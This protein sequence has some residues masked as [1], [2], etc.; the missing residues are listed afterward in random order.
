MRCAAI[1]SV[2]VMG[3]L[4]SGCKEPNTTDYDPVGMAAAEAN[5]VIV[6]SEQITSCIESTKFEAYVGD[7]AAR[8]RW[9]A[10]DQ[11]ETALAELCDQ[12]GRTDPAALATI[13]WNWT[14][15]QSSSDEV[16][17]TPAAG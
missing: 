1:V 16:P 11:S 13:H 12:L 3:I 4:A 5:M 7:A 9:D 15:A 6:P 14:A 10:A 17:I 8:A 2:V